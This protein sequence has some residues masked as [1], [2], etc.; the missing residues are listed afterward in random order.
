MRDRTLL[1]ALMLVAGLAIVE[2]WRERRAEMPAATPTQ[3]SVP[4]EASAQPEPAEPTVT[5]SP[6]S[7]GAMGVPIGRDDATESPSP[8]VASADE[9]E[10]PVKL[11]VVD[12]SSRRELEDV[13]IGWSKN[14][15][16][17]SLPHPIELAADE[18]VVAHAPSPIELAPPPRSHDSSLME[19]GFWIGA[20]EHAWT[21]IQIAFDREPERTIELARAAAL[22]VDVSGYLPSRSQEEVARD[23]QPL[24]SSEK[25]PTLILGESPLTAPLAPAPKKADALLRIASLP[26]DPFSGPPLVFEAP[27]RI[28]ETRIDGLAPGTVEVTVSADVD[29]PR[30]AGRVQV[31]LVAG[32]TAHVT[33][34]LARVAPP[35]L[36][37]LAGTLVLPESWGSDP[38]GLEIVPLGSRP[39][40][41]ASWIAVSSSEM[42]SVPGRPRA[43][44][45]RSH[46][47]VPGKYR[48]AVDLVGIA[49][50]VDVGVDGR[51]DIELVV[52]DAGTVAVTFFDDESGQAVIVEHPEWR[53]LLD[54]EARKSGAVFSGVRLRTREDG[55]TFEGRVP[56]GAARFEFLSRVYAPADHSATYTVKPGDQDFVVHLRRAQGITIQL[57]VQGEPARAPDG[58]AIDQR[59]LTKVKVSAVGGSGKVDFCWI[60]RDTSVTSFVTEPGRYRV[61]LPSLPGYAAVAP[62]DVDVPARLTVVKEVEL[63]RE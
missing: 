24:L 36:V 62:F 55:V 8:T 40:S 17:P 19:N 14:F 13:T 57:R 4:I 9:L 5:R 18:V 35:A 56:V 10:H 16:R 38:A 45:W 28:G 7:P 32:E 41:S 43:F 6:V 22:V 33:L 46:P 37:P 34:R 31:D 27:A 61:T 49:K 60:D 1:A 58:T 12:V 54:A 25:N 3:N 26:P 63:A 23:E 30:V 52:P 53:A 21:R 11:H 44:A 42:T 50:L 48:I 39:D 51:E 59:W 29:P 15:T 20:R 2:F 47:V